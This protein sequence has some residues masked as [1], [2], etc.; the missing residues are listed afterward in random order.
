MES[1]RE[2][3]DTT[4]TKMRRLE[5]QFEA[6][7]IAPIPTKFTKCNDNEDNEMEQKPIFH[8][9]N[10]KT[11][12]PGEK[13]RRLRKIRKGSASKYI[14]WSAWMKIKKEKQKTQK[15]KRGIFSGQTEYEKECIHWR[16]LPNHACPSIRSIFMVDTLEGNTYLKKIT[17]LG[18]YLKPQPQCSFLKGYRAPFSTMCID[19]CAMFEESRV[20]IEKNQKV[21]MIMKQFL[22]K[23]RLKRHTVINDTDVVT[24]NPIQ[25]PVYLHSFPGKCV[26]VFE[27]DS[28]MKDIHKKLLH[29]DGEF[30][31][32]IFPKN[33]FTNETLTMGQL[34]S[35]IQQCK[36]YGKTTWTIESFLELGLNISKFLTF[37]RKQLRMAALK[38]VMQ[39]PK[40]LEF[41]DM[42]YDFIVSQHEAN[43]KK[44]DVELYSWAIRRIPEDPTMVQWR[45]I[46]KEWYESDILLDDPHDKN[47]N[48]IRVMTETA[49]LCDKPRDLIRKFRR[50]NKQSTYFV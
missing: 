8:I 50:F 36:T 10:W 46:C 4:S 45:T 28:V 15:K 40:S 29:N 25:K 16:I 5:R 39:N 1:D 34:L 23:W 19:I 33:M 42:M 48:F 6:L 11:E 21:R 35:L 12:T 44:A 20:L 47:Y 41:F 26:Y 32:P 24:M 18:K 17:S 49:P 43:E 13:R 38:N 7:E 3:E 37:N 9:G 2:G 27:A 30:P 31:D 22:M 14:Y